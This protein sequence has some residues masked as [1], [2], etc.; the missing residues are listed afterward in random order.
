MG[1]ADG[2]EEL[3]GAFLGELLEA[4]LELLAAERI[5]QVDPGEMLGGEIRDA[6]ELEVLGLRE[7]VADA[8]EARVVDA[9][10]VAGK[11]FV[12]HGLVL[13]H[14][15]GGRGQAHLAAGAAMESPWRRARTCRSRPARR[16]CDRDAWDR[17]WPGS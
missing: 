2:L 17:Y 7:G 14:E 10:D 5:V 13:G 6:H 1:L 12:H 4:L 8:V 11:G 16:R 9:D 15:G 3:G